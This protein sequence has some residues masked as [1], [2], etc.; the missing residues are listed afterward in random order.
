MIFF[1]KEGELSL[2]VWKE[3]VKKSGETRKTK[4]VKGEEDE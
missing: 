4:K 2:Q 3:K 1:L